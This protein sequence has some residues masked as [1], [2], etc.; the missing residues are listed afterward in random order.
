VWSFP[1]DRSA[2]FVT[3]SCGAVQRL[4][5]GNTLITLSNRGRAIEVT[6]DREVVWEFVSPHRAGERDELVA[7]LFE[8]Q[9]LEPDFPLDWL[10][11][12]QEP[13]VPAVPAA[14]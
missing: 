2:D 13:L 12:S 7:N 6:P 5:N 11:G 3:Q 10:T 8:V 4:H 9:R 1:G 14:R